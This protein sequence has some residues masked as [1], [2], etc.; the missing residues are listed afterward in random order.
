LGKEIRLFHN[1]FEEEA[2]QVNKKGWLASRRGKEKVK[3]NYLNS[4]SALCSMA[5]FCSQIK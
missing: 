1:P 3:L 2:I 4:I 5:L